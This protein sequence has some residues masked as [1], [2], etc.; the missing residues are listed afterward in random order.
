MNIKQRIEKAESKT[1]PKRYAFF[2]ML[3]DVASGRAWWRDDLKWE[4]LSRI[5]FEQLV[6]DLES[7]GVEVLFLYDI[8]SPK[9]QK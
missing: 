1:K 4:G 9:V 8:H 2:T 6:Q 3:D 5:E 7:E